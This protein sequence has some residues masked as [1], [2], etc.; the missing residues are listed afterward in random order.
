MTG[1]PVAAPGERDGNPEKIQH[2]SDALGLPVTTNLVRPELPDTFWVR[3]IGYGYGAPTRSFR[4]CTDRLKIKPSNTFVRTLIATH[5]GA[6]IL[7]GS[8]LDESGNRAASIRRH[9]IIGVINRHTT[10]KNAWMWAPVR[11]VTKEQLWEYL[12]LTPPPWGGSHRKLQNLYKDSAAG[13]CPLVLDETTKPCGSTRMGCWT[14]TVVDKD[15]SI[16]G[17]I[18]SG[19]HEYEGL[20]A[21]RDWLIEIREA[22]PGVYRETIRRNGQPGNGPLRI[23][24]REK[25]LHRLV[26]LQEKTGLQLISAEE[27]AFIKQVWVSDSLIGPCGVVGDGHPEEAGRP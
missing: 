11:E 26:A 16:L 7:T 20:A 25:I 3:L 27:V 15:R 23:E 5:G 19:H 6:L 10:L 1:G 18:E 12:A 17:F 21:F 4:W 13:E 8:R 24:V 22:P 2:A 14:C 9:T